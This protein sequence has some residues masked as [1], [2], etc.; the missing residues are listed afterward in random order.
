M[1]RIGLVSD[2]A[3]VPDSAELASAEAAIAR[4]AAGD[5]LSVDDLLQLARTAEARAGR[6]DECLDA[7]SG[8]ARRRLAGRLRE[9]AGEGLDSEEAA[10]ELA[11]RIDELAEPSIVS[12]EQEL[13]LL[14]SL[15]ALQPATD[16]QLAAALG[17]GVDS[18]AIGEWALD[19][20]DRGLVEQAEQGAPVPRWLITDESLRAI[21]VPPAHE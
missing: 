21:G 13:E 4:W 3:G 14:K 19:A 5:D 10:T 16:D 9:V 6:L 8:I 7:L 2:P 20:Q 1:G 11:D 17:G 18:K 12:H 15:V